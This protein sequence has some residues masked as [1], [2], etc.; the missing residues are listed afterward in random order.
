MNEHGTNNR[1]LTSRQAWS[2]CDPNKTHCSDFKS[3]AAS[4]VKIKE[5]VLAITGS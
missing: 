1:F 2:Q 5:S 4:R 3:Q